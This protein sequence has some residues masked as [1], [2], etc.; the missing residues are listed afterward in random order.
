MT[1]LLAWAAGI[2][3]GEGYITIER[4]S[5]QRAGAFYY[6]IRVSVQMVDRPTIERLQ[7]ILGGTIISVQ[8]T[9]RN[10]WRWRTG[11][12]DAVRVL[13]MILP[14]LFTK[15]QEAQLAVSFF[16]VSPAERESIYQACR[17]LKQIEYLDTL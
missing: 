13:S 16:N 15:Q 14:Y 1:T 7:S 6:Q 9:H 12:S 11:S 8:T 2:I 10:T 4:Q 5:A 3:D 17:A